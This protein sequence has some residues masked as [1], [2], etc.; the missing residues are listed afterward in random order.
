MLVEAVVGVRTSEFH[1]T[2]P[3]KQIIAARARRN[4]AGRGVGE[5]RGH[6]LRRPGKIM[7][8]GS[9]ARGGIIGIARHRA[10][11]PRQARPA[12]Q[13]VIGVRPRD[14]GTAVFADRER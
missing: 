1:R 10:I 11:A 4:L 12:A 8:E 7:R 5:G 2:V 9:E 3:C 6:I 13:I 14:C